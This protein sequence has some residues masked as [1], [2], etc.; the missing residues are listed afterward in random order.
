M[1]DFE[2]AARHLARTNPEL[3]ELA[4]AENVLLAPELI[5][6]IGGRPDLRES[7]LMYEDSYG[8]QVLRERSAAMLS[9]SLGLD[10][11]LD[12]NQ[13]SGF[14]STR[15]ALAWILTSLVEG[16]ANP[17]FLV[18]TPC[19]QGFGWIVADFLGGTIVPV[20]TRSED[21]FALSLASIQAAYRRVVKD[22]RREPAALILTNPGNPIG[23]NLPPSLVEDIA[24]W[25]L[26]HTR[27]QL[28][29][30]E[31]YAHAGLAGCSDLPFVSALSLRSV[32]EGDWG[33]VHVA[34]G[35]AKDFG[36]SG[37]RIG[38]YLCR[39]RQRHV[40]VRAHA[41]WSPFDSLNSAT[42]A[43]VLGREGTDG[44]VLM[45]T[46]QARLCEQF[47]AVEEVLNQE[48]IP[49]VANARASLFFFLDLRAWLELAS[50]R[51]HTPGLSASLRTSE[52]NI[53]PRERALRDYLVDEAGVEL[54]PG[55]QFGTA[56][57][58]FF[59]MCHTAADLSR[60]CAGVRQIGTALRELE[61][62]TDTTNP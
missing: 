61:R 62:N 47:D 49:F 55:T 41:Q 20:E 25:T 21:D 33:R 15:S 45:K 11:A 40:A 23:R 39:D 6:S 22:H 48:S 36:V 1:R 43:H 4:V 5:A 58:G 26:R 54:A 46:F 52:S 50:A 28:V 42:M 57:P 30:D 9:A 60:V 7:D 59:R 53:D 29:S 24:T 19:W 16:Q 8:S 44:A 12:H 27:M 34:W 56:E 14:S 17:I 38:L 51:D 13:V 18:P 10:E 37:F 32:P 35:F 3:I 2:V 31:I